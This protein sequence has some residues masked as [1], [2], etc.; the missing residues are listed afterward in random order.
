MLPLTLLLACQPTPVIMTSPEPLLELTPVVAVYEPEP[1]V[2]TLED[3]IRLALH[4]LGRDEQ[5]ADCALHIFQHESGLRLDVRGDSGDSYGLGQRHAPAHGVPPDPWPVA[6]Q[7]EW[8]DGYATGRYG[9]WCQAEAR[10]LARAAKRG[11]AGWW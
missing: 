5:D 3:E 9:S 2:L 7:V 1:V 4:D 11:G 6:D 10:W 8:F